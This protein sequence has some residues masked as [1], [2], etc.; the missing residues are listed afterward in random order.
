MRVLL[1]LSVPAFEA[2]EGSNRRALKH[3]WGTRDSQGGA[4]NLRK[5]IGTKKSLGGIAGSTE[6]N[7]PGGLST[8]ERVERRIVIVIGS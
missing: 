2:L 1:G 7:E 3:Q 8:H 5:Y 4:K 6:K